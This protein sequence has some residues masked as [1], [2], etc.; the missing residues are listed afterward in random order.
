MCALRSCPRDE[1]H[2]STNRSLCVCA[3]RLQSQ[4]TICLGY[5]CV[6]L[7]AGS[8]VSVLLIQYFDKTFQH[9][10]WWLCLCAC[11]LV[12]TLTYISVCVCVPTC[13]LAHVCRQVWRTWAEVLVAVRQEGRQ[14]VHPV[15]LLHHRHFVGL[16]QD[17]RMEIKIRSEW[18]YMISSLLEVS[19]K[20]VQTRTCGLFCE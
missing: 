13:L 2:D 4:F 6:F 19:H 5:V 11:S 8:C 18:F 16:L 9:W 14:R 3:Q 12:R 17:T 1:R 20:H 10:L 7:G 15:G